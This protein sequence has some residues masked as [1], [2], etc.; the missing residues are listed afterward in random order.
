M[1]RP[2]LVCLVLTREPRESRRMSVEED[3]KEEKKVK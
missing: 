2:E 3:T 1:F